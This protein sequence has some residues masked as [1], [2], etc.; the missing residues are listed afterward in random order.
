MDITS[1]IFMVCFK[2]ILLYLHLMYSFF[3]ISKTIDKLEYME[4][5]C[6]KIIL[7]TKF[8]IIYIYFQ[9]QIMGGMFL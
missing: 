1:W 5:I 4:Y 9:T 8:E 3:L 7:I 2:Y 6:D